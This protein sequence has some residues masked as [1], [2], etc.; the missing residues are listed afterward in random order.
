MYFHMVTV[1]PRETMATVA[2]ADS[3]QAEVLL[4]VWPGEASRGS[5]ARI[6]GGGI[7]ETANT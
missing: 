7:M 3:G 4:P 5:P 6:R 1:N 2:I